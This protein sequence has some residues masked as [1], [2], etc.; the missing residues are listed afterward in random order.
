MV[1]GGEFDVDLAE[2]LADSVLI[3]DGY[4]SATLHAAAAKQLP[5][6]ALRRECLSIPAA[7]SALALSPCVA[8]HAPEA[9]ATLK[10]L[11]ASK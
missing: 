8:A 7:A 11:K 9:A 6:W 4:A 10:T 5:E 2:R 1:P 3:A